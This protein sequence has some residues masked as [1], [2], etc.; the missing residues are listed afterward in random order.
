MPYKDKEK[1]LE[2]Q[3]RFYRNNKKK[4]Q[5]WIRK[6]QQAINALVLEIKQKSQC[7]HC[8][9]NH[10]S[11]LVF[12]HRNPDEKT[13]TIASMAKKGWGKERILVEI[14]KCDI[15]CSNCHLKLHWDDRSINGPW[16]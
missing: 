9:E 3:R 11:C 10:P 8:P 12:H 13:V 1:Q 5:G 6:R 14:A 15:L 4:V 7:K 2:H 16:V